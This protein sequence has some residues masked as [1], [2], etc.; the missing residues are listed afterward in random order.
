M[1]MNKLQWKYDESFCWS[2]SALDG[3]TYI[4]EAFLRDPRKPENICYQV[5]HRSAAEDLD[6]AEAMAR[7]LLEAIAEWRAEVSQ[8]E[9][10]GD[11]R[12]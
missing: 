3:G 4:V 11:D 6:E 10:G 8:T 5:G 2:A 7:D 9:G 12:R 1:I